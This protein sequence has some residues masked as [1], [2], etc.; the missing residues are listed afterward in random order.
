ML[1][2]K[3]GT[4]YLEEDDL[5]PLIQVSAL[6]EIVSD[7]INTSDTTTGKPHAVTT[8]ILGLPQNCYYLISDSLS[9]FPL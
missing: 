6:S 1:L 7:N 4:N 9:I 3:P 8:P 5:V 2:A